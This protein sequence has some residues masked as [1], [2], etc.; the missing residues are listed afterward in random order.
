MNDDPVAN[1]AIADILCDAKPE[2][3]FAHIPVGDF[4][5]ASIEQLRKGY[6]VYLEAGKGG[7]KTLVW[8]L[9][10]VGRTGM[11]ISALQILWMRDR[12][13]GG[14]KEVVFGRKVYEENG[15]E[16]EEQMRVLDE[17]QKVIRGEVRDA[18]DQNEEGI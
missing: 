1:A 6:E 8:C 11:L 10:G 17:L 4:C 14:G 5:A 3:K 12:V 13:G 7:G 2:I 15:V 16:S 9:Y 18:E